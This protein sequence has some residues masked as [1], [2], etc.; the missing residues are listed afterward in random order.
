MSERKDWAEREAD[1]IRRLRFERKISPYT[2]EAMYRT[3]GQRVGP[4]VLC[5][6]LSGREFLWQ[7]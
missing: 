7:R 4:T 3:M 2:A 5:R 6:T 1:R